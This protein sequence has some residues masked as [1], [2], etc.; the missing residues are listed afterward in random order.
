MGG[1]VSLCQKI[2]LFAAGRLEVS[3]VNWQCPNCGAQ[4]I[5]SDDSEDVCVICDTC[6]T[7][8]VKMK[9]QCDPCGPTITVHKPH[10]FSVKGPKIQPPNRYWCE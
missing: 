2:D 9:L 5:V 6:K 10:P 4:E 3:V 1:I 8:M 7:V